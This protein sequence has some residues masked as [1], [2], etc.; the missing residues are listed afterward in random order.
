MCVVDNVFP[1]RVERKY[2]CCS[3][4]KVCTNDPLFLPSINFLI[5]L[6]T[7][8]R[9]D[10]E[11]WVYTVGGNA[12]YN[13]HCT[14]CS[15]NSNF[16]SDK[17]LLSYGMWHD[18]VSYKCTNVSEELIA[19]INADNFVPYY[20]PS[21]PPFITANRRN[22][23]SDNLTLTG[24]CQPV[25]PNFIADEWKQSRPHSGQQVQARLWLYNWTIVGARVSCTEWLFDTS[26]SVCNFSYREFENRF[27][28]INNL[29]N[30]L[31]ALLLIILI[32]NRIL[33]FE[34]A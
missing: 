21:R 22:H 25:Q 16:I 20:W 18:V 23:G 33:N 11:N 27:V 4:A 15:I 24:N 12:L 1:P 34:S 6:K 32:L 2:N 10:K 30:G 7:C 14:R 29:N 17:K 19:S 3:F 9:A 8:N 26:E 31:N 28:H 13:A 5:L